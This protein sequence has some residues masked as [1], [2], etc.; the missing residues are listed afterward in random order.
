MADAG[1]GKVDHPPRAAA[2]GHEGPREQKERVG[3][4]ASILL[5]NI[6]HKIVSTLS[7][8]DVQVLTKAYLHG[9]K[10]TLRRRAYAILLSH[11]EHT[12]DQ[13]S[14]TLSFGRD[15]ISIW[16]KT[17]ESYCLEGLIDKLRTGRPAIYNEQYRERLKVL[18][19][20]T[21]YQINGVQVLLE[22]ETGKTSCTMTIKRG[23][24]SN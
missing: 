2:G 20:Q 14:K 13:I 5:P 19:S 15:T 24:V 6:L 1:I 7:L 4:S 10:S 22:Q 8:T 18:V 21:P 11:N 9:K 3:L 12:I 17:W 16:I 23:I